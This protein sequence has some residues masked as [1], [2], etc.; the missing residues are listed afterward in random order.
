[1]TQVL[2]RYLGEPSYWRGLPV[3]DL[4]EEWRIFQ[5]LFAKG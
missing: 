1:M 4:L 3:P 2:A 5:R